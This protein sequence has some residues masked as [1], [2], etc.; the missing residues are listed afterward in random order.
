MPANLG[1]V[2]PLNIPHSS[3]FDSHTQTANKIPKDDA[4]ALP[5]KLK[6][7]HPLKIPRSSIFDSHTQTANAI[8]N[9][10]ANALRSVLR[11]RRT[12]PDDLNPNGSDT[13]RH[14]KKAKSKSRENLYPVSPQRE[15]SKDLDTHS[16]TKLDMR[17]EKPPPRKVVDVEAS[18]K[19]K[20]QDMKSRDGQEH[21]NSMI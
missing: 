1:N 21:G 2:H 3:I 14:R 6:N 19:R 12:L 11:R 20:T 8:P 9:D 13:P 10:D 5:A 16:H 15:T 17:P 7:S 18:R 4:N